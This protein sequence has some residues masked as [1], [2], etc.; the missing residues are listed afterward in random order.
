MRTKLLSLL[1]PAVLLLFSCDNADNGEYRDFLVAKPVT[2]SIEEYNASVQV[3]PPRSLE[4]S[5]K[6]YAYKDYIFVNEKFKGVHVVD[7][8]NPVQPE[9]IGF[10]NIP[11]NVDISVKGDYLYADSGND[12]VVLDISQMADINLVKRLENVLNDNMVWPADAE[13][14][15]YDEFDAT[16]EVLLGWEVVTERRLVA[17]YRDNMVFMAEAANDLATGEGGSLARFKIVGDFL[18][19]VDPHYI[20]IFNISDLDNPQDLEDVFAG[21]DIET[22]FYYEDKLFL[23]SMRGMY[24]YDITNPSQPVKVSEFQHGTACDPVVVQGNYAYVTLRGGNGCGAT[25][26][27]LFIVDLSDISDP[28][29]AVS[30][31]MDQPYGLGVRGDAV[32]VCD[33]ESGLK[34]YDKSDIMSLEQVQ[35]FPDQMAFDVIPLEDTLLMVGEGVVHQY[36]YEGLQLHWI[37]STEL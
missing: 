19:A 23:G 7:N 25:A 31:P 37:S 30:Y 6:I 3:L 35:H 4:H 21:F 28:V 22:I 9:K 36:A 18:Y 10:L 11:G 32:F 12:L 14:Y 34:V 2:M 33:G 16:S 8:S 29:L 5:G 26:S 15:D 20:N 1:I 17:E 27:G 13:I 24:I